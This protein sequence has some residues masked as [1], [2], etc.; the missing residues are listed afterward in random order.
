MNNF[1]TIEYSSVSRQ[2]RKQWEVLWKTTASAHIFNSPEWFYAC[3]NTFN[4]QD[5]KIITS[6]ENNQLRSIM[7]LVL[8]NNLGIHLWMSPG[9]KFVDKSSLLTKNESVSPLVEKLSNSNYYLQEL[10]EN[11]VIQSYLMN[12]VR[13]SSL[14][15]YLPLEKDPFQFLNRKQRS[16]IFNRVKKHKEKL[17]FVSFYNDSKAL[18]TA[19]AIDV[20][21]YK[22]D[23]GQATFISLLN[24]TFFQNLL[25]QFRK[26]F[27]VNIL[28]YD[29]QPFV[30]DIGIIGKNTYFALNTSFD[31]NFKFLIPGKILLYFLL[32][33]L[34]TR[35][36]TTFDFL[37]DYTT[38]K[39]EFTPF[40][41]QQYDLYSINNVFSKYWLETSKSIYNTILE[42]H[43]LYGTYCTFK[44]LIYHP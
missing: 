15:S 7:P 19:F 3:I 9:G 13:K 18:E 34:Q 26:Q 10:E 36:I 21:S 17:D 30:Y 20:R 1:K 35:K 33:D 6:W 37:R 39:K 16:K 27:V 2:L 43:A 44:K 40:Y 22:A 5:I 8:E 42:S 25:R 12:K 29:Q 32:N 11:L 24:R 4:Y 31:K 23:K 14:S 28:Y 41:Q 38:L